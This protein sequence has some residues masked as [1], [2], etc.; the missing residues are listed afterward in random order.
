MHEVRSF[1]GL[2][3]YYRRFIRGL[4]QIARPLTDLTKAKVSWSKV[5]EESFVKLKATLP[6]STVLRLPDFERQ[7][8]V[9][10]DASDVSVGAIL[11]QDFAHGLQ[12]IAFASRKLNNAESRYSAYE[13]EL[14]GIIWALGQWRHYFQSAPLIIVRTDH[15]PLRYLP[16]QNSV[17]TRIWKWLSI[18]QGYH[19][20]IQHIPGKVNPVDYLSS[21]SISN[22]NFVKDQV[23]E[24]DN[25]LVEQMRVPADASDQQIQKILAE[26]VQ[27]DQCRR[28]DQSVLSRSILKILARQ[29][30]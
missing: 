27:R 24:E 11:E 8:V 22:A 21:Q 6:S 3:S 4:S 1:S 28:S 26:V 18:M 23:W 14:L 20:E 2:A 9:T 17:N 5:E 7:F 13:R 19:L 30:Q 12:P 10:S 16:N 25:G 29:K 15:S